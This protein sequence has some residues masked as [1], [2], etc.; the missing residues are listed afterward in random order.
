MKK[1][2]LTMA[3]LFVA[4]TMNAQGAGSMFVKPMAGLTYS[5]ITDSDAKMKLGFAAGAEFGYNFTDNITFT[6]GLLY[7]MA[8]AKAD[9]DHVDY[10]T[11]L[12]YLNIP[13]WRM[14]VIR[15]EHNHEYYRFIYNVNAQE[16]DDAQVEKFMQTISFMH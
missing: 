15:I 3:A 6:G 2:L 14:Y 5:T 1:I 10:K 11:T 7:T 13:D 9:D 16:Y 8:G 12:N 4:V